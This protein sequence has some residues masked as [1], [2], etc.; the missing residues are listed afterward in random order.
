MTTDHNP[1]IEPDPKQLQVDA[2]GGE[3]INV[4]FDAAHRRL[5][6][7]IIDFI[8]AALA[9]KP[10]YSVV[11]RRALQIY[12]AHL[13]DRVAGVMIKKEQGLIDPTDYLAKLGEALESERSALKDASG[14]FK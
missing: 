8:Q 7:G 10:S 6:D 14:R 5:L 11:L 4:R 13:A 3:R 12:L 2:Y 9:L 1:Q